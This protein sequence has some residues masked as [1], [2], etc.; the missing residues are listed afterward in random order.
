MINNKPINLSDRIHS[1]DLLRGFAVM[2]ILIMN[3]QSFSQIEAAYLNPRAYGDFTGV[4]FMVWFFSHF[5]ADMKF[6]ALFSMLFGAGVL[7]FSL[8]AETKT[9]GA[10]MLHYRRIFWLFILGMMHAYLLWYGDILVTYAVAGAIVYLFRNRKARTLVIWGMVSLIAGCAFFLFTYFTYDRIP[11]ES[12]KD[13]Q[14]SWQPEAE[15]VKH[16]VEA[17][18]GGWVKQMDH[19]VEAAIMLQAFLL[20]AFMGWRA[21]GLMLLGMALFKWGVLS[22]KRSFRFYLIGGAIGFII[23]FTL[24]GIGYHNN[25]AVDWE[26]GYSMF[27]GSQFNYWGSVFVAFGYVCLVML[28]FKKPILIK[29][30]ESLS[31]AGRMAFTNYILQTV[32]STFI[33]YGHGLG[34]FG[35]FPRWRQILVVLGICV[36]QLLW[37]PWW[38][39]RYKF[40]PLEWLWRSLTYWK[41]QPI[42]KIKEM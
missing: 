37:S 32:I 25:R 10:A 8:R 15:L 4:N 13:I 41:W 27:C 26:M 36:L 29:L 16:E 14:T 38:L 20:P 31:A 21:G 2:G 1:L 28:V 18:Q 22:A 11:P 12:I 24:I 19:R 6:M 35:Q 17:Y 7:L 34:L 30:K 5:L 42:K 33:F 9:G 40:G 39:K 3:I 23:G